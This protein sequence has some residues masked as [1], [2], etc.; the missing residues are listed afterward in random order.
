MNPH[1]R[2][3]D[4]PSHDPRI[5]RAPSPGD[6]G[7]SLRPVSSGTSIHAPSFHAAEDTGT[8]SFPFPPLADQRSA[9]PQTWRNQSA[10]RTTSHASLDRP[11]NNRRSSRNPSIRIARRS[12]ASLGGAASSRRT[13]VTESPLATPSDELPGFNFDRGR[14]RSASQPERAPARTDPS[15]LARH[16]RAVPQVAMP[17]L[18]EEGAR[19]TMEEL[20][21]SESSAQRPPSPAVS[22]PTPVTASQPP[23]AGRMRRMSRFFWP[24]A[25]GGGNSSTA[26]S[27]PPDEA[28][29][30]RRNAEYDDDMVDYL[31]TIGELHCWPILW[32][33]GDTDAAAYRSRSSDAFD[34][35][36]HPE[37]AFHP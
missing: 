36:Q 6:A 35:H 10:Y 14:A 25:G 21:V 24:G 5:T 9:P 29:A 33:M 11:D 20:G 15:N 22:L 18:T 31:D 12:N 27:L 16:S 4:D 19:P 34:A 8:E 26:A 17:R 30:A 32:H 2:P 37:L 1:R 7:S 23:H 13:S 3:S 28:A